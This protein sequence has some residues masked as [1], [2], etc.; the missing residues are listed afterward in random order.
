MYYIA[1]I[2]LTSNVGDCIHQLDSWPLYTTQRRRNTSN[3]CKPTVTKHNTVYRQ[4]HNKQ[5]AAAQ[6]C[7]THTQPPLAT[8]D[9][10]SDTWLINCPTPTTE[11]YRRSD[12]VCPSVGMPVWVC[13]DN[14]TSKY[15]LF[16]LHYCLETTT[17]TLWKSIRHFTAISRNSRSFSLSIRPAGQ[18]CKTIYLNLLLL[19]RLQIF[20]LI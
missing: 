9:W 4:V 17:T 2:L 12:R 1:I 19:F 16:Y 14:R 11:Q 18:N 3:S 5:K 13:P 6:W 15:Y 10:I 7:R 8:R 20:Q